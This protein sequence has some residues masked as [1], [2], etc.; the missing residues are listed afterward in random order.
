MN[1]HPENI[2]YT[3]V[4]NEKEGVYKTHYT[5]GAVKTLK[6]YKSGKLHGLCQTYDLYGNILTESS[7][8]ENMLYGYVKIYYTPKLPAPVQPRLYKI[9]L[10]ENNIKTGLEHTFCED[11]TPFIS[12]DYSY[13]I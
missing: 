11:G 2:E 3:G 8:K 4:L 9:V 7:Y 6:S 5:N 13:S 1:Y 12:Y 10:Y